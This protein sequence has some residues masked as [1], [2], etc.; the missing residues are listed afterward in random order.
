[1]KQSLFTPCQTLATLN[2]LLCLCIDSVWIV[3]IILTTSTIQDISTLGQPRGLTLFFGK[4][5]KFWIT[6]VALMVKNPSAHAG[7]TE[8]CVLNSFL[9]FFFISWRLITLQYCSGF[10]HTLTWITLGY[11]CIPHPDPPSHLHLHPIPLGLLSAPGL[12]TCL[13]HPTGAGDLFHPR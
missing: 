1:M 7:E 8:R 9:L 13:M 3:K 5:S 10:C 4:L 6:Q 12:S 2:I 11:T